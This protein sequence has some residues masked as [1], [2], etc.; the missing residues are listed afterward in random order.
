MCRIFLILL[1]ESPQLW[2]KQCN[3]SAPWLK[4]P[5]VHAKAKNKNVIYF[6]GY[7]L[8][9]NK[10]LLYH[11]LIH[12]KREGDACLYKLYLRHQLHLLLVRNAD[13][14][15]PTPDLQI[16]K[17][18]S[19]LCFNKSSWWYWCTIRFE[20]QSSKALSPK[21]YGHF[22]VTL[23]GEFKELWRIFQRNTVVE[24]ITSDW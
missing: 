24:I 2:S 18:F 15:A 1:R 19:C 10:D 9:G 21:P 22:T 14:C 20:N 3:Q 23:I 8:F 6:S 11:F 17:L 4:V 5:F 16:Q 12:K 7:F 13:P